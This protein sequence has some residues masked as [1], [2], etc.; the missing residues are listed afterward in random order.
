MRGKV[1]FKQLS[2]EPLKFEVTWNPGTRK[3]RLGNPV[4]LADVEDYVD[5][6]YNY[7]LRWKHSQKGNALILEEDLE[8]ASDITRWDFSTVQF[9]DWR[10]QSLPEYIRQYL[11]Q[12]YIN[13]INCK[14]T[15]CIFSINIAH[16]VKAYKVLVQ[17]IIPKLLMRNNIMIR[18]QYNSRPTL[19]IGIDRREF[20][21]QQR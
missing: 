12:D 16:T 5:K 3:E 13:I 21:F 4:T 10:G 14:P 15:S 9:H 11:E 17:E 20:A 8:F 6:H 1:N 19:F 18:T 2:H 7:V